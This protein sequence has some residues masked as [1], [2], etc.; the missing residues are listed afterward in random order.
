MLVVSADPKKKK[1]TCHASYNASPEKKRAASR[2]SYRADPEEKRAASRVASRTSGLPPRVPLFKAYLWS[3]CLLWPARISW[4]MTETDSTLFTTLPY[5]TTTAHTIIIKQQK[6]TPQKMAET[7]HRKNISRNVHQC[8]DG[9]PWKMTQTR[10]G[11]HT[12]H[13][14]CHPHVCKAYV[15][16][17]LFGSFSQ[18]AIPTLMYNTLPSVK[19]FVNTLPSVKIF[20]EIM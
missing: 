14:H 1:A 17:F 11:W 9:K 15:I 16:P 20:G 10:T 2:V 7:S 4:F 19:I 18:F 6:I 13:T 3:C 12:L 5:K 8:R